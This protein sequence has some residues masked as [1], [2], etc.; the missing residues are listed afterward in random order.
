MTRTSLSCSSSFFLSSFL[1]M[2]SGFVV[3]VNAIVFDEGD[4]AIDSTDLAIDVKTCGSPPSKRRIQICDGC[5]LPSLSMER[6]NASSLPSRDQR[7]DASRGPF[8]I[9]R[10][11]APARVATDQIAVL[12]VSFFSSTVTRTNATCEPSGE[13]CGSPIQLNLNRSFSV[14]LR[15]EADAAMNRRRSRRRFM[16]RIVSSRAE[17]F[18]ICFYLRNLRM[19]LY[20]QITQMYADKRRLWLTR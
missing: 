11:S 15:A 9:R 5:G 16:A 10:G 18:F 1:S 13:S 3:A 17:W 7:G 12:Y 8:V 4:Q 6:V 20:P 2:S 14:M 19:K